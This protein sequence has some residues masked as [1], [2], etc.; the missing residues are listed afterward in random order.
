MTVDPTRI[1][2]WRRRGLSTDQAGEM[3]AAVGA[4]KRALAAGG[5]DLHDLSAIVETGLQPEQPRSGNVPE[6]TWGPPQPSES[7]W[8]GMCWYLHH[9]RFDIRTCDREFVAD[10]LLGIG[11]GFDDGRIR[12]WAMRE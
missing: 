10:M 1:G 9:H 3:V 4:L 2:Q 8:Q 12:G 5:K 11:D 7:D 6:R